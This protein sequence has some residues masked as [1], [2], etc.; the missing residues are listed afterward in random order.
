MNDTLQQIAIW[1]LPVLF[2]ITAHEA[3]HGWV[4]LKLGDNTAQRLGRVT[5]NPI[6]HIDLIGTIMLPLLM[7]MLSGFIFGWAKPVPVN[8]YNLRQPRR[9]MALVAIAGPGVNLCMAIAWALIAKISLFVVMEGWFEPAIFFFYVGRAGI[10]INVILMILNLIPILPLDGGRILSSLLP[11]EI[12][13]Q[14]ARS[15][16]FGLIILVTLLATGILGNTLNYM[17]DFAYIQIAK[18]VGILA[19]LSQI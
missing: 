2:A 10:I 14:F 3:A 15:E 16:P 1:V 8:W 17:F 5:F 19:P 6:K 12:A 9:D 7:L 11:P 4:A 13:A 18:L